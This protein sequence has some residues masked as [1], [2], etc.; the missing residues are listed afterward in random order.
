MLRVQKYNVSAK[1]LVL[2]LKIE[3]A[4]IKDV[5][6]CGGLDYCLHKDFLYE[7]L[8]VLDALERT[9]RCGHDKECV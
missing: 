1:V 2:I 9:D 5:S 4:R 8:M 6:S 7:L 3:N